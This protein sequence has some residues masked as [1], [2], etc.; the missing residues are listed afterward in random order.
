MRESLVVITTPDTGEGTGTT[1]L[2]LRQYFPR[3]DP[4]YGMRADLLTDNG[5]GYTSHAVYVQPS[6]WE[7]FTTYREDTANRAVV[8][9]ADPY[10]AARAKLADLMLTAVQVHGAASVRTEDYTYVGT[11]QGA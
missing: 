5:R 3:T 11:E 7:E 4:A 9:H 8:L 1:T 2:T 10:T 6:R